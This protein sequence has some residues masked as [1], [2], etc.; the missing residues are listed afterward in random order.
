MAKPPVVTGVVVVVVEVLVVDGAVTTIAIE[1]VRV[2]DPAV[3]TSR[4][5]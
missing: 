4:R 3:A 5:L 1:A 2:T